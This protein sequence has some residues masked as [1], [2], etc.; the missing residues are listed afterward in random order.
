MNKADQDLLIKSVAEVV[1]RERAERDRLLDEHR[2]ALDRLESK[3]TVA[4]AR[5]AA[6]I[7]RIKAEL[8]VMGEDRPAVERAAIV[9][10]LRQ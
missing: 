8:A 7:E 9:A 3:L 1:R 10:R 2:R 5:F 4:E 6:S